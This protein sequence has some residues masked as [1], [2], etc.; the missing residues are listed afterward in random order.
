LTVSS[1]NDE[2]PALW[3]S[4]RRGQIN[5]LHFHVHNKAGDWTEVSFD[6]LL[7]TEAYISDAAGLNLGAKS[8]LK[9]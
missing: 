3:E 4:K 8:L 5:E 6:E 2:L 9:E 7:I 1:G